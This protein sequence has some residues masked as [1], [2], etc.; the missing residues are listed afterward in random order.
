MCWGGGGG[1]GGTPAYSASNVCE[2]DIH[3]LYIR[4]FSE[5][6]SSNMIISSGTLAGNGTYRQTLPDSS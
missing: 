2:N 3:V 1:G 6:L 4:S 5:L